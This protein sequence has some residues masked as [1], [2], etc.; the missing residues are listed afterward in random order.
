MKFTKMHGCLN[1]FV[2]INC[3]KEKIDTNINELAQK[4]C[5]RRNGIGADG[6]ILIKP[7]DNSDAFMGIYNSDGSQDTMCGNG[8]RCVAK[9]IYDH[10]IVGHEKTKFLID[11][12]SGLKK[13]SLETENGKAKII[14]VDIG[15]AKLTS[16]LPEK[17]K[18]HNF[19]LKFIG[20]DTGTD[21]AVY[22]VEDNPEIKNINSWPDSE[23]ANEG[24]YFERHKRFPNF[25]SS[26]F[27]EIIS[28]NEINMRVF[29]RGCGET[30]ACGTGATASAFAGV[31]SGKLDNEVL[32][33][34]RGGDLKIKV[35]PD[36]RC[37]LTGEAVEVFS[38]EF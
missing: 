21:H 17:I 36:N 35:E 22:F 4:M 34:L 1:D 32:V 18:I 9:Y 3:F 10:E 8:I 6:L 25:V 30:M 33:H 23:F 27:I 26:D 38:G 16:E 28:R 5:D 24:I 20:V 15:I 19:D 14:T 12:L 13:I 2:I 7:S 11:T 29:E 37:F 31:I